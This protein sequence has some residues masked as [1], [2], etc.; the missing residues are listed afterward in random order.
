MRTRAS[1]VRADVEHDGATEPNISTIDPMAREARDYFQRQADA[2][3]G[4]AS[5]L[6][7]GAFGRAIHLLYSIEGHAVVTGIGKSG[8]IGKKIASTLSATGTP[9]FFLHAAEAAHGDLGMITERDALLFI[10]Y[11]GETTEILR[12]LPYVRERGVVSVALVGNQDS[13]LGRAVDVALDVSVDRELC[14]HN[15]AP[16]NS[17]LA[18]MAM[19]DALVVALSRLRGFH[20]EDFAQFHPGGN[21]GRRLLGRVRDAMVRGPLPLVPPKA[22]AADCVFALTRARQPVALVVDGEELC[23]IVREAELRAALE[24][25]GGLHAEAHRLMTEPAPVIDENAPIHEAE[26]R[27]ER[28]ALDALVALDAS[29]RIAGMLSSPFA[30]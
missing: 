27:F 14:P 24:K 25:R 8:L 1:A 4:L 6:E 5:R 9:S 26:N 7:E 22:T 15:L 23:G 13:T 11:S 30:R 21:L 12:L 29:G 20:A 16:T 10:S 18:T 28:E 19:G 17:T 2:I 3:Q